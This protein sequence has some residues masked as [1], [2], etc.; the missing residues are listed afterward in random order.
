MIQFKKL[1]I[2]IVAWNV[3]DLLAKCLESIDRFKG[4]LDVEVIVVD[5]NSSDGSQA[6]LEDLSLKF[7][8]LRVIKNEENLGFA[9]GN[10]LGLKEAIGEYILFLNPDTQILDA[11]G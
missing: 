6:L 10:N 9:Q 8:V 2:I 1:S 7:N 5:N 3:K 11:L 4:D